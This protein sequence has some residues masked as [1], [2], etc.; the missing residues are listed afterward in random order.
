MLSMEYETTC[1][2]QNSTL[3]K[4]Q[5]MNYL[6]STMTSVRLSSRFPE[7]YM[8]TTNYCYCFS[9][10]LI[11]FCVCVHSSAKKTLSEQDELALPHWTS[12]SHCI[13]SINQK[14]I[15]LESDLRH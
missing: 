8:V 9:S 1:L 13:C 14:L 12:L 5:I 2:K 3:S 10:N 15:V 6:L 7:L 4:H 11:S